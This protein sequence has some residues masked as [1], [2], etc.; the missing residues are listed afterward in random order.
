[1]QMSYY[2]I[3]HADYVAPGSLL[4]WANLRGIDLQAIEL[5]TDHYQLPE[6]EAVE[7]LIVLGGP[8]NIYEEET[9]PFLKDAKRLIKATIDAEVKTLGICLGG[10]LI[11]DVLGAKVRK[12]KTKE[13]GWH[14]VQ[15]KPVRVFEGF[16]PST[17]FFHW[18]G[19][20]FEL[21]QGAELLASSP[22]T[23]HQAYLWKDHVLA[24][25]FHPEMTLEIIQNYINLD[26]QEEEL[27]SGPYAQRA[28]EILAHSQTQVA[29]N[30]ERFWQMLDRFFGL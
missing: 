30:K 25:Q 18:H 21:P 23:P 20:I 17:L 13:I 2:Y 12:N 22:L 19:D 6:A 3:Q 5:Y 9:Y 4:E 14:A 10:Q 7:G 26:R 24:L 16:E 8:M 11:S 1:M 15:L 29:P 28:E 27:G